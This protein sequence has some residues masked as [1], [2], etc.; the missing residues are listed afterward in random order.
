MSIDDDIKGYIEQFNQLFFL[1]C[2]RLNEELRR[3]SVTMRREERAEIWG[4]SSFVCGVA[5]VT[6][7][8]AYKTP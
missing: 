1:F 3:G 7:S 2:L 8:T 5:D 4:I 6:I